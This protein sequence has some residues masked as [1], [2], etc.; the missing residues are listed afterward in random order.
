MIWCLACAQGAP[1]RC[2][3]FATTLRPICRAP[4]SARS[5]TCPRR[6][7]RPVAD[8]D[9]EADVIAKT[10]AR[11][12][13]VL[14]GSLALPPGPLGFV[15]VLPDLYLI[16]KTQRQMVADIFALYGRSAELTRMHMLYCLFRHAASQALRDL[17]V[18][19]GQRIVVEQLSARRAEA[20]RVEGRRDG[21]EARRGQR[22]EPLGAARRRGGGRRVRVLGHAAGRQDRARLLADSVARSAGA[23]RPGGLIMCGRYELHTHP[24]AL[25]L[26]FG[27]RLSAGDRA[28]LQHR[29]D[30]G[31]SG[32]SARRGRASAS[33]RRCAGDSCRGGRRTRRSARGS[34][35]RARETLAE[36]PAFRTALRRHRVPDPRRRLL[37]M[38]SD[39]R[40]GQAAAA[41]RHE[42]RR[43]VRARGPDRAL[44]VARRRGARH[45]RHRDH[46][47]QRAAG[48][49][50]RAH[51]GD[52]RARGLRAL[53]R[54]RRAK[55]WPIS[56][57]PIRPRRWR[58]GRCRVA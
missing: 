26:A 48:A 35:T 52:H 5:P 29:A 6:E 31:R 21:V 39:S 42:G 7:T 51:A 12:A 47:G 37:R 23:S 57:R 41:R 11:Q 17:V 40:C 18:R 14:S 15:T 16:W 28:A 13:A 36:K 22:G 58:T 46:A 56:S 4:S 43:A 2:R 54:C 33:S 27:L 49:D 50:A 19:T 10:A 32:R 9:R 45:L 8:P 38:E 53:A 30:A 55:R 3:P 1:T 34:S 25:A 20:R 44:A 24:A